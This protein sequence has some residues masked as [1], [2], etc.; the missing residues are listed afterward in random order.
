ME[1]GAIMAPHSLGDEAIFS[2]GDEGGRGD[3]VEQE[4]AAIGC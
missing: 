3:D 2:E 1:H 4:Q